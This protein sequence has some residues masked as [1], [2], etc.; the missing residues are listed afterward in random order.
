MQNGWQVTCPRCGTII[1]DFSLSDEW[2][3][4]CGE[5]GVLDYGDNDEPDDDE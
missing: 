4:D 1:R 5:S 2:F 3:C